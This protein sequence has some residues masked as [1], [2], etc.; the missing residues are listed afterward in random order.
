MSTSHFLDSND[1]YAQ[2]YNIGCNSLTTKTFTTTNFNTTNITAT[3]LITG[4]N[5]T[6]TG[7]ISANS[8]NATGSIN[9]KSYLKN[10]KSPFIFSV[11]MFTTPFQTT[12][13]NLTF[14]NGV[15]YYD[16]KI[17]PRIK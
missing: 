3:G 4:N 14:P 15:F 1:P 2:Y 11:S 7:I 10:G 6:S 17:F 9:A 13:L 5:I 12:S 16:T 8:I